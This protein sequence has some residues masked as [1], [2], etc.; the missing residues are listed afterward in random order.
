[1]PILKTKEQISAAYDS[2]R[3][4]TENPKFPLPAVS[5][6]GTSRQLL[7]ALVQDETVDPYLIDLAVREIRR[8]AGA[9]LCVYLPDSCEEFLPENLAVH[10]LD[11]QLQLLMEH[12]KKEALIANLSD[13]EQMQLLA[14]LQRTGLRFEYFE[15]WK[16][17]IHALE[18]NPT[19]QIFLQTMNKVRKVLA[20][21]LAENDK[22]V[23]LTA[24][25]RST[26]SS[27]AHQRSSG[28]HGIEGNTQAVCKFSPVYLFLNKRPEECIMGY[29]RD[30]N[31]VQIPD[32]SCVPEKVFPA[33]NGIM[34]VAPNLTDTPTLHDV[35][36]KM[37]HRDFLRVIID[38]IKS[39][40]ELKKETGCQHTDL[41]ALNILIIQD[42][43]TGESRG[44]LADFENIMPD[45]YFDLRPGNEEYAEKSY[46]SVIRSCKD[47]DKF[48][49]ALLLL[50][51]YVGKLGMRD[52]HQSHLPTVS[53]SMGEYRSKEDASSIAVK[54]V[55][56][57]T[58]ERVLKHL[59][60]DRRF[61][62]NTGAPSRISTRQG[63]F[64]FAIEELIEI[65][66]ENFLRTNKGRDYRYIST[67]G[68]AL[69][70]LS[71]SVLDK[72]TIRDKHGR[73]I[74][75]RSFS[76]EQ[77][78]KCIAALNTCI[79]GTEELLI[80]YSNQLRRKPVIEVDD[81]P[82]L[83]P[84]LERC[85]REQVFPQSK[86]PIPPEIQDLLV[87]LLH[88]DDNKRPSLQNVLEVLSEQLKVLECEQQTE[89]A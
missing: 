38:V 74:H 11:T 42:P 19:I 47:P 80:A 67:S 53:K 48:A 46:Y 55:K 59:E 82:V 9:T 41:K 3:E 85:Y 43:E 18:K 24:S 28:W 77:T 49:I 70:E 14:N 75:P 33:S 22:S 5:K 7:R 35:I 32:G 25:N 15:E 51:G 63:Q 78:R 65:V 26:I 66:V 73:A 29:E 36:H 37:P 20:D 40:I 87:D 86:H 2:A 45:D 8:Q 88:L 61:N 39:C 44:R 1:M 89:V 31:A 21:K 56:R 60:F 23:L 84:T 69:Q 27:S 64:Q 83:Q 76:S 62:G 54:F 4:E 50:E 6:V 30:Y 57:Y 12:P 72:I 79:E 58:P 81:I 34:A 13:I 71:T 68:V 10:M 17:L 52:L 16:A